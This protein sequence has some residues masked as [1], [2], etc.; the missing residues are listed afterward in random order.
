MDPIFTYIIVLFHIILGVIFYF[1][2]GGL[3]LYGTKV[4]QSNILPTDGNCMPYTYDKPE[5]QEI[6][7]NIF[8]T[9][10]NPK[11]SEKLKFPYDKNSSNSLL[12][13]IRNYKYEANSNF[14]VNYILAIIE[15]L[16]EFDYQFLNVIFKYLNYLPEPLIIAIGLPLLLTI[17]WWLWLFNAIYFIYLWFSKMSWFFKTNE[18]EGKKNK[19]SVWKDVDCE[20]IFSY[21]G[22]LLLVLVF[23]ILFWIILIPAEWWITILML[24]SFYSVFSYS[25]EDKSGKPTNVLGILL[26]VFKYYK[27]AIFIVLSISIASSTMS[28]L[29]VSYFICVVLALLLMGFGLI[30]TNMFISIK[31]D[32][33]TPVVPFTQAIKKCI[34]K[35]FETPNE[36]N[37]K[38]GFFGGSNIKKDLKRLTKTL[39]K[40]NLKISN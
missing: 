33:L 19:P 6:Y 5:I 28:I 20:S 40:F 35:E 14:L 37:Q 2:I 25:S 30:T 1:F 18:N 4:A 32:D 23:F 21:I 12:D 36:N 24:Y 16:L 29:G 39:G 34:P 3:M 27:E 13:L 7:T 15:A 17:K 31:P 11:L 26:K 10:T 22:G 38:G 9:F 8:T